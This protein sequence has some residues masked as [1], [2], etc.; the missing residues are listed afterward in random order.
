MWPFQLLVKPVSGSCNLRCDYCFYLDV[1]NRCY[2]DAKETVMSDHIL[3]KLVRSYLKLG[4]S[5]SVFSWQGG[6]PT[7]AGLDFFKKAVRLETEFGNKGQRIGNALQTNGT[8]IDR[9]WAEFLAKY[10][11]LVGLSID[12]PKDIHDS[13]RGEGSWSKAIDCA[14]LLRQYG[15]KFN[16]L[17]VVHQGNVTKAREIYQFHRQQDFKNLQ[18]IPAV[19]VNS[20]TGKLKKHSIKSKDYGKFLCNLFD[21][22]MESGDKNSVSIRLFDAIFENLASTKASS[23]CTV[24]E[25]CGRYLVVEHNGD[26]YSCDFFVYPEHLLGNLNDTTWKELFERRSNFEEQ[27]VASEKACGTCPWWDLCHGGCPKNRLSSNRT[28]LCQG[29]R[30]FFSHIQNWFETIGHSLD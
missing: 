8:R 4:F 14:D 6:E 16:I 30:M 9:G 18:F 29:Y 24:S 22:W 10:R 19:D 7:L 13:A 28:H 1:P 15:I 17:T 3:R 5:T 23:L 20:E 25:Q 2:P 27:K 21:Q 26:I 12:G 11:F